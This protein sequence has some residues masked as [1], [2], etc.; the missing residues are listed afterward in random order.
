[1]TRGKRKLSGSTRALLPWLL[2]MMVLVVGFCLFRNLQPDL[3]SRTE[4]EAHA[5]ALGRLAGG[6]FVAVLAWIVLYSAAIRRLD[7][8]M[9]GV[10][11]G[12]L[13]FTALV[14]SA[15]GMILRA[16]LD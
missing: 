15:A 3:D 8:S 5:G 12:A 14:S 6:A 4:M 7:R 2:T 13:V 10:C 16:V 1:M 9:S 11:L